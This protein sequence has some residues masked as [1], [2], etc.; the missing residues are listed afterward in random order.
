MYG[1]LNLRFL[2]T[3]KMFLLTVPKFLKGWNH[4]VALK[5]LPTFTPVLRHGGPFCSGESSE[6]MYVRVHDGDLSCYEAV[7]G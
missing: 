3:R 5:V 1:L 6:Y 2:V 7:W 4:P